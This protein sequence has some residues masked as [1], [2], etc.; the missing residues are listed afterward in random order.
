MKIGAFVLSFLPYYSNLSDLH[1]KNNK[2]NNNKKKNNKEAQHKLFL[3]I[4][5]RKFMS[6]VETKKYC[7][8]TNSAYHT[9][10]TVA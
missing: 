3:F 5:T 2:N 10:I 9:R 6:N 1:K 8:D 7:L 4:K